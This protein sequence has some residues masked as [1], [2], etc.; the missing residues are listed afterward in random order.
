MPNKLKIQALIFSIF[1]FFFVIILGFLSLDYQTVF[2]KISS[3][4]ATSFFNKTQSKPLAFL[5]VVKNNSSA[6]QVAKKVNNKTSNQDLPIVET[7]LE[8]SVR[9]NPTISISDCSIY[10]TSG[11]PGDSIDM[12]YEVYNPNS[13]Y[14]NVGLGASIILAGNTS[15]WIN[16][17]VTSSYMRVLYNTNSWN[18][19]GRYFIIPD[20]TPPGTYDVAF[21]IWPGEPGVGSS[22]D[23]AVKSSALTVTQPNRPPSKPVLN[24][25]SNNSTSVGIN[26]TFSWYASTDPDGDSVKYKIY[27]GTISDPPIADTTSWGTTSWSRD[28]LQYNTTYYWKVVAVD[29]NGNTSEPSTI[30]N[31]RTLA[32]NSVPVLSEPYISQTTGDINTEF[33]FSIKY[34]DINND[35]PTKYKLVINGNSYDMVKDPFNSSYWTGVTYTRKISNCARGSYSYNFAFNDGQA[36]HSDVSIPSSQG[37]SVNNR[38]PVINSGVIVTPTGGATNQEITQSLSWNGYFSDPD[39]DSLSYDVY[40][41]TSS[42]NLIYKTSTGSTSYSPGTLAY[43]TTYYWQ[44]KAKDGWG[45]E[46]WGPIWNFKTKKEALAI[47]QVKTTDENGNDKNVFA[48]G[49][50]I[51]LHI[52]TNHGQDPI[53]LKYDVFD[54]NGNIISGLSKT[55]TIAGQS[56][57]TH[58]SWTPNVFTS[59]A[60]GVYKFKGSAQNSSKEISFTIKRPSPVINFDIIDQADASTKKISGSAQAMTYMFN[61]IHHIEILV[62]GQI[63]YSYTNPYLNLPVTMPNGLSFEWNWQASSDEILAGSHS[64]TVRAYDANNITG[65]AYKTSNFAI[66]KNF[67]ISDITGNF[68]ETAI[69]GYIYVTPGNSVPP[70]CGNNFPGISAC[71]NGLAT[72]KLVNTGNVDTKYKITNRNQAYNLRFLNPDTLNYADNTFEFNVNRNQTKNVN[73]SIS[74]LS[75]IELNQLIDIPIEIAYGNQTSLIHVV[76]LAVDDSFYTQYAHDQT[77]KSLQ[78]MADFIINVVFAKDSTEAELEEYNKLSDTDASSLEKI[79]QVALTHPLESADIAISW[80]FVGNLAKDGVKIGIKSLVTSGKVG[81]EIVFKEFAVKNIDEMLVKNAQ[82]NV[83]ST[84]KKETLENIRE[85]GVE[86]LVKDTLKDSGAEATQKFL[87]RYGALREDFHGESVNMLELLAKKSYYRES[88]A[89]EVIKQ[90]SKISDLPSS[91]KLFTVL[92]RNAAGNI[93]NAGQFYKQLRYTVYVAEQLGPE[94]AIKAMTI[95]HEAADVLITQ[96]GKLDFQQVKGY[97]VPSNLDTVEE[98]AGDTIG[99]QILKAKQYAQAQNMLD[100]S[101]ITLVVE[102]FE[103]AAAKQAVIDYAQKQG[104]RYI[105]KG[106][107]SVVATGQ[108]PIKFVLLGFAYFHSPQILTNYGL[109]FKTDNQNVFLSGTCDTSTRS[110]WVDNSQEGVTYTPGGTN[111]TFSKTMEKG[112]HTFIIVAKDALGNESLPASIM[113]LIDPPPVILTNN[114]QNFSTNNRNLTLNGTAETFFNRVFVNGSTNG[115]SYNQSTGEWSYSTTLAESTNTFTVTAKTIE[116]VESDPTT[117]TI[118]F[119]TQAPNVAADI[120]TGTYYQNQQVSLFSDDPTVKIYYTLDGAEP[121]PDSSLYIEPLN[122]NA[123]TTLKYF[124]VDPAGNRSETK[125]EVYQ[126]ITFTTFNLTQGWNMVSVPSEFTDLSKFGTNPLIWRYDNISASWQKVTDKLVPGEGYFIWIDEPKTVQITLAEFNPSDYSQKD[127]TSGWI[128]AS[129]VWLEH[130]DSFR[131]L[132]NMQIFTLEQAVSQGL[133]DARGFVF[134]NGKYEVVNLMSPNL[135]LLK[136]KSLWLYAAQSISFG[137]G[138]HG[139]RTIINSDKHQNNYSLPQLPAIKR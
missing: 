60:D 127:Y 53:D 87:N 117:I 110:I 118:I 91:E 99:E 19:V 135:D 122:I 56:S 111:W 133:L 72:I 90:F 70:D 2:A 6:R 105:D 62:D 92:A 115:V 23:G 73:L 108:N 31:F 121:T 26:P 96:G 10:P 45:G 93:T 71:N 32:P 66:I 95:E 48:P 124:A 47:T 22:W 21:R 132:Y 41:G 103:S 88:G 61:Y 81:G 14:T 15:G 86:W 55:E 18:T 75:T 102:G 7:A 36:G 1:I 112:A 82:E 113:L 83:L 12:T 40:L 38:A 106:E 94:E 89:R 109:G 137:F 58:F 37:F 79:F 54:Q 59:L 76:Y 128:L 139:G 84:A 13:G 100:K 28:T 119:D 129:P 11:K 5:P 33:I 64:I 101:E 35:A 43:D 30:W 138:F 20:N 65:E 123:D 67:G 134:T 104:L 74:V 8:D 25:P 50:K 9:T 3:P 107:I 16:D 85:Y 97:S 78:N 29:S 120:G 52:Y 131:I 42:S 130:P 136:D 114:G 63:K 51:G 46:T 24:Y 126:I 116:D 34:K 44:L 57:Q 80:T 4:I 77:I 27:Y 98:V 69:G 68:G 49:D 17:T 125:T 39:N